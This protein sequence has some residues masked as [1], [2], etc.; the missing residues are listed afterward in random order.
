VDARRRVAERVLHR[1]RHAVLRID[2]LVSVFGASVNVAG[3]P[4]TTVI[5][6]V[7]TAVVGPPGFRTAVIVQ[8]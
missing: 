2:G 6:T 3:L 5:L 4:G 8:L 1:R 7:S